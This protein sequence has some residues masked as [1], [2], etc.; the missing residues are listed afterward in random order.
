MFLILRYVQGWFRFGVR[1]CLD[2]V[3]G[4][5]PRRFEIVVKLDLGFNLGVLSDA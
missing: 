4:C 2:L 1:F 5:V 3:W